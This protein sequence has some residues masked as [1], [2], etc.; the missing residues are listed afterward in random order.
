M[1]IDSDATVENLDMLRSGIADNI[2]INNDGTIESL[3]AGAPEASYASNQGVNKI[4][5]LSTVKV[6]NNG[7]IENANLTYGLETADEVTMTGVSLKVAN[8]E[9]NKDSSLTDL[10]TAGVFTTKEGSRWNVDEIIVPSGTTLNASENTIPKNVILT[11]ESGATITGIDGL[12]DGIVDDD[13]AG[14]YI[15]SDVNTVDKMTQHNHEADVASYD[16]DGH[17]NLCK[18][19]GISMVAKEPHNIGDDN[20]CA[21][22]EFVKTAPPLDDEEDVK[23]PVIDNTTDDI[24]DKK[25]TTDKVVDNTDKDVTSPKTGDELNMLPWSLGLVVA[26]ATLGIIL[27]R[28]RSM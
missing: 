28:K 4:G 12:E 22:C 15:T 10:P 23:D 16:E 2:T 17:W 11:L 6:V 20:K 9:S 5:V 13:A 3:T 21:D 26:G 1:N 8:V 27:K 14:S 24:N 18:Y 19:C 25:D 7:N